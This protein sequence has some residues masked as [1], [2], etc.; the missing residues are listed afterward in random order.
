MPE[1]RTFF[2]HC[3]A[4]GRRFEIKLV[5][6]KALDE[7]K[8]EEEGKREVVMP[9]VRSD[10]AATQ[11]VA[12]LEQ[13]PAVH[14]DVESFEYTYLCKHCG[15]RWSEEREARFEEKPGTPTD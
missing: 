15:H 14:V 3:P 10:S 12:I 2:R 4:C 9:Q 6:R 13:G 7:W 11:G 5:S 8:T 1:I